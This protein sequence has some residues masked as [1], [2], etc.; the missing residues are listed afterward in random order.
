MT[1]VTHNAAVNLTRFDSAAA[2]FFLVGE[3]LETPKHAAFFRHPSLL[4]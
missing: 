3:Q 1:Y 2:V 4:G